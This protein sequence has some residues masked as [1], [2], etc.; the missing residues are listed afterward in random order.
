MG[1]LDIA[2]LLFKGDGRT[3]PLPQSTSTIYATAV[4]DSAN[5]EVTVVMDGLS[6]TQPS[7]EEETVVLSSSDFDDGR[8][9]LPHP[10]YAG[11]VSVTRDDGEPLLEDEFQVDGDVITI[12]ALQGSKP[13]EI[14]YSAHI[15]SAVKSSDFAKGEDGDTLELPFRPKDGA[16][17][18]LDGTAV[19]CTVSGSTL[20]ADGVAIS[21]DAF[22]SISYTVRN[23]KT[24]AD[25]EG[26]IALGE[27]PSS[28]SVIGTVLAEGEDP[29]ETEI[30]DFD[31]DDAVITI[32]DPSGYDQITA[33][34]TVE[35]VK[36]LSYSDTVP[37]TTVEDTEEETEEAEEKASE[38]AGVVELDGEPTRITVT[39]DGEEYS[40][41]TLNGNILEL[42]WQKSQELVYMLAYDTVAELD[43]STSDFSDGMYKLPAT[44]ITFYDEES[45]P[46]RDISITVD[47][48]AVEEY[49]IEDY[50]LGIP[51]L[52]APIPTYSVAYNSEITDGRITL[53]TAPSVRSGET[54]QISVVNGM[55]VVTSVIG[56]GDRQNAALDITYDVA[57]SSLGIAEEANS[58]A[59]A[60]DSVASAINQRFWVDKHG[61]HVTA[62]DQEEWER[63]EKVEK[64]G[65][66]VPKGEGTNVLLNSLGLMFMEADIRRLAITALSAEDSAIA[67]YDGFG[68]EGENIIASFSADGIQLGSTKDP[69]Q[70][71]ISK[72]RGISFIEGAYVV[73]YASGN[74][75]NAPNMTF[76]SALTA[77]TPL[78]KWAWVPRSNGNLALKWIG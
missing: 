40:D 73:A 25:G 2:Q 55:P 13:V 43:L 9:R 72:E 28:V 6:I 76:S 70:L 59:R 69:V 45:K 17:L 12:Y 24:V 21:D 22:F 75:F 58:L 51:S 62:V 74:E 60:A 56:E 1:T 30:T 78:G 34:Y 10:A 61:A 63:T 48:D 66:L 67:I 64:E 19:P 50:M 3:T 39:C 29:V 65:E 68:N 37:E 4:S 7:E 46:H 44:P 14:S 15:T 77:S 35:K 38:N 8:T 36:E 47:G 11:T 27:K 41:Y 33:T 53:P 26:T 23:A 5:G 49:S 71:N 16:S 52:L 42:G 18:T 57:A 54:V 20:K 32:A 31:L